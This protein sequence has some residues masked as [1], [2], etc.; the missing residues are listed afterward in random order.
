MSSSGRRALRYLAASPGTL[1]GLLFA[2]ITL[3]F[4]ATARIRDGVLEVADGALARG[5]SRLLGL[6]AITFGHVV[7]GTSHELLDRERAHEHDHVR[8]YERWSLLFFPLYL[9]S[10]ALALLRGKDP[11]RDNVFERRARAAAELRSA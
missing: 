1:P 2:G 4:G 10:S 3:A 6:A 9:G 11:Y 8:Q 5:T 7:L